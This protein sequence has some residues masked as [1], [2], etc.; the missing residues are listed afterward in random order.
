MN[1]LQEEKHERDIAYAALQKRLSQCSEQDALQLMRSF[2]R[3]I[4]FW[5]KQKSNIQEVRSFWKTP[6]P[7]IGIGVG[8]IVPVSGF[9]LL[10]L[11]P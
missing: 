1:S 5:N 11:L 10:M 9:M 4:T 8:I 6:Y 3:Q 2:D 7:Y